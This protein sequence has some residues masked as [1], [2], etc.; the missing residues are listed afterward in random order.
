MWTLFFGGKVL[1]IHPTSSWPAVN[2][3]APD[4]VTLDRWP[5][6]EALDPEAIDRAAVFDAWRG[7]TRIY[8]HVETDMELKQRA[9]GEKREWGQI[10]VTFLLW[11]CR[12]EGMS[13][14]SLCIY[15]E[16]T[17]CCCVTGASA[18]SIQHKTPSVLQHID[19]SSIS[20]AG[21]SIWGF[22]MFPSSP[23]VRTD[24]SWTNMLLHRDQ[25]WGRESAP[26]YIIALIQ[27]KSRERPLHAGCCS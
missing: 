8:L 1:I 22:K 5:Q 16:H 10:P 6:H 7:R 26:N 25:M 17:L 23:S 21:F 15:E 13:D 2:V 24:L 11:S 4:E 9:E 18:A 12:A 14:I 3:T 27:F 20:A 19:T